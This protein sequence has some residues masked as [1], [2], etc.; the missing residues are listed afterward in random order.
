[1]YESEKENKFFY[2]QFLK[3]VSESYEIPEKEAASLRYKTIE[4]Y[5]SSVPVH[6]WQRMTGAPY[7]YSLHAEIFKEKQQRKQ[8]CP[9]DITFHLF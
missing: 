6:I 9:V 2:K 5:P 3:E 8:G 7:P 4:A 1:H